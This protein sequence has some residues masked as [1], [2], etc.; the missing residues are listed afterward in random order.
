[1]FVYK[2]T[3]NSSASSIVGWKWIVS[4]KQCKESHVQTVEMRNQRAVNRCKK[5]KIATRKD[6]RKELNNI[7]IQKQIE[8]NI[9]NFSNILIEWIW[10]ETAT[11]N[12]NLQIHFRSL[13]YFNMRRL[14]CKLN[15]TTNY[16]LNT[17]NYNITLIF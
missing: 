4:H 1:M 13:R 15:N 14:I 12:V 10:N 8:D 6:I 9:E 5:W 7:N 11:Q 17:Q 3:C 2:V 16:C